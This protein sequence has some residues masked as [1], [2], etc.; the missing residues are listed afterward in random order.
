MYSVADKYDEDIEDRDVLLSFRHWACH[1]PTDVAIKNL[2]REI[3]KAEQ[4]F[5]SALDALRSKL[6]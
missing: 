2:R 5:H 6:P 4:K 1:T 3:D